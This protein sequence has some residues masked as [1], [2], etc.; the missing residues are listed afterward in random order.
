MDDDKTTNKKK[1]GKTDKTDDDKI[2]KAMLLRPEMIE[3]AR[4]IREADKKLQKPIKMR[5][6]EDDPA[7]AAVFENTPVVPDHNW[8]ERIVANMG[9]EG[10]RGEGIAYI[11]Y[12]KG[13]TKLTKPLL[14]IEGFDD[15]R[16]RPQGSLRAAERQGAVQVSLGTGIRP[17]GPQL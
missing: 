16:D 7:Y 5:K 6:I 10:Q 4:Q 11:W 1:T 14:V 17:R 2:D 3:T 12:G 9:Y 8:R 13:N 15:K